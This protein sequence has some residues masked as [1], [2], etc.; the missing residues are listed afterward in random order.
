MLDAN[1][2]RLTSLD[3]ITTIRPIPQ[4]D[5]IEVG[6]VRGWSVVIGRGD[7]HDGDQVVYIEPDAALPLDDPRFA[8]LAPRGTKTIDS[9]AYH[10][11]RTIRLRGQLSQGIVFPAAAFPELVDSPDPDAALGI[12]LY[13]APTPPLGAEV[14]GPWNVGWLQKTDA[15]R[16]QNLSDD[17]LAQVDDGRWVPTE[18]VDGSSLTY[19]LDQAQA[20]HVY[21]RNWE[22]STDNPGA[23]PMILAEKY[24]ILDWMTR[25]Q[26]DAIQGEMFGNK[27]QDNRLQVTGHRLACF[28]AWQRTPDGAAD[29]CRALLDHP[30]TL[31]V[32]PV[33][34]VPFPRSVDQAIAQADGL[35]SLVNPARLAEGIVWHHLDG[36]G[37][38]ELGYRLVFKAVSPAYL[39][40]H[41]L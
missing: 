39:I 10:V 9:R 21:N 25:H 17:W 7:F 31:E 27:I 37:F 26:V 11:V 28:A 5:A 35:T 23:T 16:V 38:P 19:V 3:T 41:K 14:V 30:Q 24:Q 13:E 40:K 36:G 32:A 33:L 22:L 4:A 8:F 15:E 12:V 1:R 34:D 29:R 20:L 18:K 2:R 6:T